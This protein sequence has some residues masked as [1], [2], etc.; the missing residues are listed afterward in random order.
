MSKGNVQPARGMRDFLPDDAEFRDAVESKIV[1][2]YRSHGYRKIET[3][4]ME[5]IDLLTA[6]NGGENEKLIFKIIKRGEKLNLN[7]GATEASIVE[8]GLRFDLTLP[9]TRFFACNVS[10]LVL[11]FKSIQVGPVWRAERPQRGRFRQF[12]QCDIDII[13]EESMLAEVDLITTTARCLESFGL[14]RFAIRINDRRLLEGLLSSLG[15]QVVDHSSVMIALDKLD[16]IGIDG[17]EAELNRFDKKNVHE[18]VEFMKLSVDSPARMAEH[19]SESERQSCADA[20]NRLQS[21]I[22]ATVNLSEQR[23]QIIFDP[24]LVRG[25]GYYTGQIFEISYKDF[26]FSIAGGGRYDRMIGNLLGRD[27]PACGFSIGFERLIDVLRDERRS[28][29]GTARKAVVLF[30]DERDLCAAHEKAASLRDSFE[31]V[32]VARKRGNHRS[33]LAAFERQGYGY[34]FHF[35]SGVWTQSALGA[36]EVD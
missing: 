3:P 2:V 8:Y 25:M 11:P 5:A 23:Y 26:P 21:V 34:T 10:N 1:S 36:K 13:G 4:T 12:V 6:G 30:E 29:D 19:F 16:K 31:V 22:D 18:L 35:R 27:T 15:F 17:V 14:E 7:P 32:D 28:L 33:Q 20:L 9:L 24:Y